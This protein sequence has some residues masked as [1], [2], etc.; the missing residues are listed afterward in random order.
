[1]TAVMSTKLV[2]KP[3]TN[4]TMTRA[5]IFGLGAFVKGFQELINNKATE[6]KTE[7]ASELNARRKSDQLRNLDIQSTFTIPLEAADVI[8]QWAVFFSRARRARHQKSPTR[9]Q[10][11]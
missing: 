11:R 10:S 8:R 2:M 6:A 3:Q 4:A 7:M 9:I 5:D 1:M